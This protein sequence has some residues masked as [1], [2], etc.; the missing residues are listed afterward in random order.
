MRNV[1]RS[2]A[3]VAG[4]FLVTALGLARS[5]QAA[6]I[7]LLSD[8]TR[9]TMSNF[10]TPNVGPAD[11]GEF[12][13][14]ASNFTGLTPPPMGAGVADN[15]PN[16]GSGWPGRSLFQT[17]CLEISEGVV[18]HNQNL[19]DVEVSGP[20]PIYQWS[21]GTGAIR[22]GRF[23]NNGG[24]PQ[25]DLSAETAFLYQNFWQGTLAGY[26]YAFGAGR[27]ASA[28]DLQ[29]AIWYL[30]DELNS[31]DGTPNGLRPSQAFL[32]AG[33][34]AFILAAQTAV[35][36]GAW[37]GLGSVRVLNLTTFDAQGQIVQAQSVL[38][39]VPLPPAA[40]LG[41]GL[42]TAMGAVGI[43]RRRRQQALV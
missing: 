1:V 11:G 31:S 12:G 20:H 21:L 3:L 27:T 42:M 28:R 8:P 9:Y 4:A 17:F 22:G 37:S 5:A 7:E 6:D 36:T 25:D 43:I 32:T 39:L 23:G 18:T 15:G 13:V 41:L 19:S 16:N 29:L 2:S 30:E 33:A 40:W 24:G 10:N 34:N 26:V 14:R 38:V 35:S